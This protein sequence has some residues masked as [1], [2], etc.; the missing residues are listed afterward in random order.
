MLLLFE[1]QDGWPVSKDVC[2][3]K[4]LMQFK[5]LTNLT[6]SKSFKVTIIRNI[7]LLSDNV[8]CSSCKY[9][10]DADCERDVIITHY[11]SQWHRYDSLIINIFCRLNV[12]RVSQG[13]QSLAEEEYE[14]TLE[15]GG[16]L[17]LFY[18]CLL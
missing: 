2:F 16:C 5:S 3:K 17:F 7:P 11:T 15:N 1:T 14:N 9:T 6:P 13:K 12:K 4:K 8:I 18:E 10:M